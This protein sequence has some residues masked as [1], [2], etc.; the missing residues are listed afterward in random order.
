MEKNDTGQLKTLILD[1][2]AAGA[3]ALGDVKRRAA[4]R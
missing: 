3:P 2:A 1:E 4:K